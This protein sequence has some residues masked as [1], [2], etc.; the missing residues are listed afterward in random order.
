M[1]LTREKS[2]QF[3][4]QD[5]DTLVQTAPFMEELIRQMDDL[6]RWTLTLAEQRT[7]KHEEMLEFL[8]K[9]TEVHDGMEA[10]GGD[11]FLNALPLEQFF[12]SGYCSGYRANLRSLAVFAKFVS[13]ALD[14]SVPKYHTGIQALAAM[15][16]PSSLRQTGEGGS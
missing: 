4:V 9:M 13:E 11:A 5:L 2:D 10:A 1:A 3:T 15:L 12:P 8:T 6:F 14:R 16:G 7:V